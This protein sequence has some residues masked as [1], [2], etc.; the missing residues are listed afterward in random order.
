MATFEEFEGFEDFWDDWWDWFSKTLTDYVPS[1][2]IK[3]AKEEFQEFLDNP[4]AEEAVDCIG[5]LI[6]WMINS[7]HMPVREFRRKFEITKARSWERMPDGRY[8]HVK[9]T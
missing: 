9:G 6:A 8:H 7:G 2:L 1:Q 5:V 3:K 4:C